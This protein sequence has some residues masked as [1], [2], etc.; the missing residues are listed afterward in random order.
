MSRILFLTPQLPYPPHQGAA[1][2]NLNLIKLAA[3][4]HEVAIRAFVRS[5]EERA[6]I[7]ALREWAADIQVF[8]APQRTIVQRAIQTAL[9]PAPDMHRRLHST[10]FVVGDADVVQAEGIEMVQYLERCPAATVFDCHNAEWM[11]QR[12]TF[13]ADVRR[14]RPLGAAYSLLQWL[15]LRR[16]ERLA[17]RRSDAVAAVSAED[18]QALLALDRRL[19]IDLIPN[20]VDTALF[21]P[22]SE[23]PRADTFLFTGTLDFRPNVDAVRWLAADIW[24]LIRRQLPN[25]ELMLAGRA[26]LPAIRRLHGQDGIRVAASPADI[27]PYFAAAAVYLAPLRA[28]GGSR[29]KLLQAMSMG[30][31]IVSTTVGAEGLDVRDG[32]HLR[33]A[34][35][36]PSL[37]AAAVELAREA[38]ARHNLGEAARALVLRKYDWPVLAPQLW[39]MY[40]RV[41]AAKSAAYPLN[42]EKGEG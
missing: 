21:V 11:L 4:R 8:P 16:Y 40:D 29:Y 12:R 3:Q 42:S 36:P 15:K 2:R 6:G 13:Q 23:P 38:A 22:A 39:A 32:I 24:P 5:P 19:S 1:I 25:A 10:E 41:L 20:G 28:G 33:L 9:S 35:D 17:C 14:G 27:R 26:P 30:M 18:C 34:E 37:A 31:G 7:N